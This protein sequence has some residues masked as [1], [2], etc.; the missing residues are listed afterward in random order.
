M[1]GPVEFRQTCCYYH[2]VV[3]EAGVALRIKNKQSKKT[4]EISVE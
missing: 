1:L 2:D 4:N 3:K